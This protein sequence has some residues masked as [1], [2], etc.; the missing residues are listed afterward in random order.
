MIERVEYNDT[1]LGMECIV[2]MYK[3]IDI[4]D[5]QPMAQAMMHLVFLVS[6]GCSLNRTI[7]IA[8]FVQNL[9][10]IHNE[11]TN[12]CQERIYQLC[13]YEN[14]ILSNGMHIGFGTLKLKQVRGH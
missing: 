1:L 6:F 9:I 13:G 10:K 5:L 11:I 3:L 2:R 7:I 12:V 14:L 4:E 8:L